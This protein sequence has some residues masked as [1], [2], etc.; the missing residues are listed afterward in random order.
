MCTGVVGGSDFIWAFMGSVPQLK[1][2]RILLAKLLSTL[3]VKIQPSGQV[4]WL[5]KMSRQKFTDNLPDWSK[6]HIRHPGRGVLNVQHRKALLFGCIDNLVESE[7]FEC[8]ATFLTPPL[9]DGLP[10]LTSRLLSTMSR[11]SSTNTKGNN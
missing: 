4:C 1:T 8:N 11:S 10:I 3:L 7:T 5:F 6:T 9:K 2:Q